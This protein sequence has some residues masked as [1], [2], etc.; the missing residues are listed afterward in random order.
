MKARSFSSFK[1][2][3]ELHVEIRVCTSHRPLCLSLKNVFLLN[4]LR[5]SRT[6]FWLHFLSPDS[7]QCLW[8]QC[9]CRMALG[10]CVSKSCL[11]PLMGCIPFAV[12]ISVAQSCSVDYDWDVLLWP[13]PCIKWDQWQLRPPEAAWRA[14]WLHAHRG[15][16]SCGMDHISRDA[17]S[18]DYVLLLG[19][20]ELL[21]WALV[22]TECWAALFCLLKLEKN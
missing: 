2:F 20:V 22:L 15:S 19:G 21:L 14:E 3:S 4:F 18:C 17:P 12:P 8:R 7:S 5:I 9:W 10:T 16:N 13:F 6:V 1:L 11:L